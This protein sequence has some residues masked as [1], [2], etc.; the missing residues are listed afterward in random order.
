MVALKRIELAQPLVPFGLQRVGYQPVVGVDLGV[1]TTGQFGL[2]AGALKL[3]LSQCGGLLDALRDLLL[4]GQRD[5][6]SRGRD[7]L[8]QQGADGLIDGDA[9][10]PQARLLGMAHQLLVATVVRLQLSAQ[11]LVVHAH[12]RAAVPAQHSTLEQGIA[13]ARRAA[14]QPLENP[15]RFA[16]A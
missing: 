2:V 8:E 7:R 16:S 4:N 15:R 6:D 13:L 3:R 9:L 12:A 5:L 1:A 10:D 11:E 14:A